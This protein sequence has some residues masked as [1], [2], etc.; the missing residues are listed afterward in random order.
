MKTESEYQFTAE[1][2]NALTEEERHAVLAVAEYLTCSTIN[3]SD[4]GLS[5]ALNLMRKSEGCVPSEETG[6]DLL[7]SVRR[8]FAAVYQVATELAE[9]ELKSR[10]FE[11]R[12]H[13]NFCLVIEPSYEDTTHVVVVDYG[14]PI[15]YLH[16]WSEAWHVGFENLTAL[17]GT[18]LSTKVELINKVSDQ[19]RV[20]QI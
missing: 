1:Q 4:E 8:K 19:F 3:V 12:K 5:D 11:K 18:V 17:A 15:C 14:K 16:D 7:A 2:F 6:D 9:A 10:G 20:G 13:F